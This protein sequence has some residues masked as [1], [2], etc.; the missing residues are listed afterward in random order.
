M[1]V[2]DAVSSLYQLSCRRGLWPGEA[3]GQSMAWSPR[4]YPRCARVS[5]LAAFSEVGDFDREDC[6]SLDLSALR[7]H[8]TP[9]RRSV[10]A[11]A[12]RSI[13]YNS[14]KDKV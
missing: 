3:S 11:E 2:H 14:D 13:S 12:D 4:V 10:G 8:R 6:V 5:G 1:C 7:I 9:D